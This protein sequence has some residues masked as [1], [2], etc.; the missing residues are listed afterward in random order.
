MKECY[1]YLGDFGLAHLSTAMSSYG[2]KTLLV[3]SAGF[4]APEQL[5]AES[6]GVPSDA[7]AFGGLL[8]TSMESNL[9]G[10]G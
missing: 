4:Q 7:Y 8:S 1:A 6:T 10:Q 9:C 2:T 5:K 3:G